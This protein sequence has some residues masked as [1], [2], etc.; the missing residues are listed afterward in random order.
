[1]SDLA[2]IGSSEF[3]LGFSLA[4]IR[5]IIDAN[6]EN[7]MTK[8]NEIISND[9]IG[10]VIVEEQLLQTLDEFDRASVEDSVKPIFVP[11]STKE[12]NDDLRRL[13]KK[14]VGVDLWE[15]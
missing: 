4:G 8:V 14:S 2:V 13:I 9:N 3:G 5:H 10:V 6:S 15:K 12:S 11:L 7:L 1:M